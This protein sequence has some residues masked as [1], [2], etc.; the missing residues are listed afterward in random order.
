MQI[1]FDLD[2]DLADLLLTISFQKGL[3]VPE[4]CKH[5]ITALVKQNHISQDFQAKKQKALKG[6]LHYLQNQNKPLSAYA[7]GQA[8][9]INTNRTR[10]Y[11]NE[12][13]DTKKIKFKPSPDNRGTILYYCENSTPPTDDRVGVL[14]YLTKYPATP[15]FVL[16][17]KLNISLEQLG[18]IVQELIQAG[19]VKT[20]EKSIKNG[21]TITVLF[22]C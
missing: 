19:K 13:I 21:G 6:I 7:I 3:T 4:L 18:Q 1:T 17:K 20:A 16:A 10:T 9:N 22:R 11:L 2:D 14:A 5:N 8:L 15:Y 12:L